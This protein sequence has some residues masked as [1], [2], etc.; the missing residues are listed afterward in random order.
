MALPKAS[1]LNWIDPGTRFGQPFIAVEDY[2]VKPGG[3]QDFAMLAQAVASHFIAARIKEH[4]AFVSAQQIRR[5]DVDK[6]VS[7]RRWIQLV[8]GQVAMTLLDLAAIERLFGSETV[9]GTTDPHPLG[10]LTQSL[11]PNAIGQAL[12]NKAVRERQSMPGARAV[13]ANGKLH[14]S[15]PGAM[16]G[17]MSDTELNANRLFEAACDLAEGEGLEVPREVIYLPTNGFGSEPSINGEPGGVLVVSVYESMTVEPD[18]TVDGAYRLA[19]VE[20]RHGEP[21][22]GLEGV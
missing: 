4:E 16:M 22:F 18:G 6:M 10:P 13:V 14:T 7:P 1:P 20:N 12:M 8:Y 3:K 9:H 11:N 21:E 2:L 15:R 17:R 19:I 5:L